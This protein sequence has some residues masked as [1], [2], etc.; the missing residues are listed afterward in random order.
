M[1]YEYLPSQCDVR[2]DELPRLERF[3]ERLN[4][5]RQWLSE[6]EHSI[7][8]QIRRMLWSDMVFRTINECR[9]LATQSTSPVVGFNGPVAAFIDQSYVATQLLAIR[10]LTERS[11]RSDAITLPRLL[12]NMKANPDLL[13]ASCTCVTTA[14]LS[15]PSPHASEA[16]ADSPQRQRKTT[17]CSSLGYPPRGRRRTIWPSAC[18]SISTASSEP[19]GSLDRETTSWVLPSSI[20]SR[21]SLASAMALTR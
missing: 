13:P 10:R 19:E 9:R 11:Q 15:I 7:W 18:M 8:K 20:E 12:E 14:Y 6:D 2:V 3:R 21:A 16:C 17:V 1:A 4:V 5:W